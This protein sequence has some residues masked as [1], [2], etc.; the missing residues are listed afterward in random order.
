MTVDT[1]SRQIEQQY[2]FRRKKQKTTIM[3]KNGISW[4][5]ET[6][7]FIHHTESYT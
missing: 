2:T 5:K 6:Q 1:L 4:T 7:R 3:N